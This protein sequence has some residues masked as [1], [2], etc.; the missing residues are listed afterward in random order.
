MKKKNKMTRAQFIKMCSCIDN[1]E[2][3]PKNILEKLFDCI[4][5][6]EIE[7]GWETDIVTFFNPS[8]YSLPAF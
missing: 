2:N 1:G 7:T 6:N 5:V 3:V 8:C 4:I